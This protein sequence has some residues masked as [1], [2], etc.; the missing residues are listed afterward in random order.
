MILLFYFKLLFKLHWVRSQRRLLVK[1]RVPDG[2]H[3]QLILLPIFADNYKRVS[4]FEKEVHII[5][6]IMHRDL[7][8]NQGTF[9]EI[10]KFTSTEDI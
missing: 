2:R 3:S 8:K 7:K 9:E 4:A 5:L 6:S 10:W 1:R